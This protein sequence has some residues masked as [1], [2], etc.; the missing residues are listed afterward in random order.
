MQ[1]D[2]PQSSSSEREDAAIFYIPK[3]LVTFGFGLLIAVATTTNLPAQQLPSAQVGDNALP[4]QGS[5][6]SSS[7]SS[8]TSDNSQ[9]NNNSQGNDNSQN[10]GNGTAQGPAVPPTPLNPT[11]APNTPL[12]PQLG[13][14]P[15]TSLNGYSQNEPAQNSTP[16]LYNTGAF[17]LSQIATN[18]A[19]QQ[20]YGL[21]ATSGFR[22]RRE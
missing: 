18:N 17:N 15:Y 4:I 8:D 10:N 16:V 20:A 2:C 5:S 12:I 6:S 22:P 1:L 21:G 14:S 9:S 3:S 13:G 7:Q 11:G 19:L